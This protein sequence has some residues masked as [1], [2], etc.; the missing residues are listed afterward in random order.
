MQRPKARWRVLQR[1]QARR[2][3]AYRQC[4]EGEATHICHMPSSRGRRCATKPTRKKTA[5]NSRPRKS[6]FLTPSIPIL[7]SVNSSGVQPRRVVCLN[8][9]SSVSPQVVDA[10]YAWTA[11]RHVMLYGRL[12]VLMA[13]TLGPNTGTIRWIQA[14]SSSS[15]ADFHAPQALPCSRNP[16]PVTVAGGNTRT[17]AMW[18]LNTRKPARRVRQSRLGG[19]AS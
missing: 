5:R 19:S 9:N 8:K 15:V 2:R 17:T 7:G 10:W 11:H 1:P 6:R 4:F 13:G 12:T 14:G 18:T 3:S 16:L